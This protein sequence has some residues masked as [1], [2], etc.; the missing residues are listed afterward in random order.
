YEVDAR[1][2]A[3]LYATLCDAF[4]SVESWSTEPNDLVFICSG[5]PLEH[6]RERIEK[7]IAQEPY[8]TVL[9]NAWK[10]DTL[11]G[12]YAHMFANADYAREIAVRADAVNTDDRNLVEFGFARGLIRR[13]RFQLD[14]IA[15]GA[16]RSGM[17][18][19]TEIAHSLD[20]ARVGEE[21]RLFH[22]AALG[23]FPFNE[24]TENEKEASRARAREAYVAGRHAEVLR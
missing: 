23:P 18:L 20:L 22:T 10:V 13:Q 16:S 3:I 2:I 5:R 19:P 15:A 6:S 14:Q 17:R 9:R 8:A 21:W 24:T 4:G 12:L 11:E 1:S 7:R